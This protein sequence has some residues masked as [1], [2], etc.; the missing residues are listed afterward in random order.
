M[1]KV[2]TTKFVCSIITSAILILTASITGNAQSSRDTLYQYITGLQKNPDD[3]T[4][5]Q[6][7]I[8][9][10]QRIKPGLAI[11]EEARRSFVMGKTLQAESKT[12]AEYGLAVD[13]FKAAALHA[14]WYTEYY[15]ELGITQELAGQYDDAIKNIRLYMLSPLSEQ[16]RRNAQDELYVIEAKKK[17]AEKE[18][19]DKATSQAQSERQARSVEG[20]WDNGGIDFQVVKN[21]EKFSIIAG[22]LYGQYGKWK[23]TQTV[24]EQHH[25]RFTVDQPECPKCICA[26]DL[27]LSESGNELTGTIALDSGTQPGATFNRKR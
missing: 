25:I 16:D 1:V 3:Y 18:R 17:K 13:E 8:L 7:I 26:Y 12:N 20:I 6:K 27:Y 22:N 23:A 4:L 11:P 10:A 21:G 19:Q 2:M 15:K 14:P 24:I 9:I 5:R